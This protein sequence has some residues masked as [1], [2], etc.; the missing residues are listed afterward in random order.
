MMADTMT[1]HYAIFLIHKSINDKKS[2]NFSCLYSFTMYIHPFSLNY[3]ILLLLVYFYH[4]CFQNDGLF[5]VVTSCLTGNTTDR[6]HATCSGKPDL[7]S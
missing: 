5:A 2:I 6:K 1:K 3:I 4:Y 7:A